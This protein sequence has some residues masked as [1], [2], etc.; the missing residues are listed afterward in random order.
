MEFE[1]DHAISILNS[2]PK[3]LGDLLQGLPPAWIEN[4]EGENT[5]S[6]FDVVGHL[7][8]GEQVNWIPR[9]KMILEFGMQ[10]SFMPFDRFAQF[11][12]SKG[13]TIAE[14]LEKFEMLRAQNIVTLTEMQL[15]A[16]DLEK[17]GKHPEFGS[18]T[19]SQ[20]LATWVA[21]DLDHI[22]QISRTLA[23]NYQEAVG[24]W[25]AYLSVMKPR[26]G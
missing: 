20:L 13:K 15:T 5:W 22:V 4:N 24:P 1:I 16:Q 18:I 25:Q 10:K 2:T 6:P 26:T 8:Y 11:E 14:L 3:V 19:L 7:I 12:A 17:Q 9:A 21:H 23:K